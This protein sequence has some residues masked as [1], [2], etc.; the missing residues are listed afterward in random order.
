MNP[1]GYSEIIAKQTAAAN[2]G[3]FI[4]NENMP[5][6]LVATGLTTGDEVTIEISYDGILWESSV[7]DSVA[8]AL[9]EDNNPKTIYGPGMFRAVKAITSGTVGVAKWEKP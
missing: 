3:P 8:D 9:S 1:R 5:V 2:S 4:V 7:V 6:T